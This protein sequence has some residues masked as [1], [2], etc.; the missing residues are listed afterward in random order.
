M[1]KMQKELNAVL[2]EEKCKNSITCPADVKDK[3][4]E[5]LI[6]ELNDKLVAKTT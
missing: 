3:S 4:V 2:R 6:R 1:D 5:S